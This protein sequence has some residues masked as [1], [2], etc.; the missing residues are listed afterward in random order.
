MIT[1]LDP[2]INYWQT[3]G[4]A[5]PFPLRDVRH[6]CQGWHLFSGGPSCNTFAPHGPSRVC[7]LY[8]WK[9]MKE[10]R[11]VPAWLISALDSSE[12]MGSVLSSNSTPA[13][14][15]HVQETDQPFGRH[16]DHGEAAREPHLEE[17]DLQGHHALRSARDIRAKNT[18][19]GFNRHQPGNWASNPHGRWPHC[20]VCDLRLQY[21]PRQGSPSMSTMV[22]NHV[23][24][25]W[26]NYN[27]FW[28]DGYCPDLQGQRRN[29]W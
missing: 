22:P 11:T 19:Q 7:E 20:Q 14:P 24:V 28:P 8:A 9:L 6:E 5:H 29:C 13:P 17:E 10:H 21:M 3:L 15:S 2:D 16:S 27:N 4:H 23:M 25:P 26:W 1:R 12:S 18:W